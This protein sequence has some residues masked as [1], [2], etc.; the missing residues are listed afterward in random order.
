MILK[1]FEINKINLD[2]NNLILFY[3]KNEGL[4]NEALNIYGVAVN[5]LVKTYI[6]FLSSVQ[7]PIEV[8]WRPL[9][10]TLRLQYTLLSWRPLV[11]II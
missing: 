10:Q 3:G 1:S 11:Y 5:Y 7:L 6:F 2:I 4:K 9:V 8:S